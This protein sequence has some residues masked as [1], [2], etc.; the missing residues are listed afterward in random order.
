MALMSAAVL[1]AASGC[2]PGSDEPKC[3]TDIPRDDKGRV[4]VGLHSDI[5]G[6]SYSPDDASWS[7][8]DYDFAR[9]LGEHCG[10]TVTEKKIASADRETALATG[11]V[12]LVV[13]SYSITDA[14]KQLVSF[15]GPYARTQQGVMV[16][17][18]SGIENLEDLAGRTVCAARGTTSASQIEEFVSEAVL[19][20]REGFGKCARALIAGEVHAVSTDQ[21]LLYGFAD[22]HSPIQVEAEGQLTVLDE[23]FG[24][25]EL[26][27]IGIPLGEREQCEALTEA[28]DTA[29]I[30]QWWSN[31]FRNALPQVPR[32]DDYKPSRGYYEQCTGSGEGDDT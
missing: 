22:D 4:T 11:A 23:T 3:M 19:V 24:H 15:A 30:S 6:W 10:F 28:I 32:P 17:E 2:V 26:Y 1:V 18:A 29:I 16:L 21:L 31:A 25:Q 9:W 27:G 8:F 7:G 20:E 14:R 13:A 12:D 5:P